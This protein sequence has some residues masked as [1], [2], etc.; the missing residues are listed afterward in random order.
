MN[1]NIPGPATDITGTTDITDTSTAIALALVVIVT[2][3][4]NAGLGVFT[5]TRRVIGCKLRFD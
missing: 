1:I 4:I 3:A 5:G 2:K